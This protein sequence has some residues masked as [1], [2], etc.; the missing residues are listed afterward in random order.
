MGYSY[1]SRFKKKFNLEKCWNM[2]VQDVGEV[3]GLEE[4]GKLMEIYLKTLNETKSR[5]ASIN[6]VCG[7]CLKVLFPKETSNEDINVSH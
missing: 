4:D 5:S 6:A 3:C 2:S 1:E 7:Y